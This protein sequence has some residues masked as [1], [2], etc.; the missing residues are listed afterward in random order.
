MALSA[1]AIM[2]VLGPLAT[3]GGLRL[4][5][6]HQRPDSPGRAHSTKELP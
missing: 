6:E 1:I 3:A 5:G 4:A 2:A